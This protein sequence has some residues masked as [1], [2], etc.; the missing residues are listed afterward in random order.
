MTQ[1][2]PNNPGAVNDVDDLT[3]F[4]DEDFGTD[5]VDLFEFT[6]GEEESP[7]TQLKAIILGLDWE[8]TDES[9]QDLADEIEA[10]TQY[11]NEGHSIL[12]TFK[13]FQYQNT[14]PAWDNRGLAP[15]RFLASS[16]TICPR[17]CC[18]L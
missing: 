15:I 7:L 12:G 3:R 18:V 4:L 1:H 14:T 16:Q 9:L 13:V 2:D 17:P 6:G 8:I 5:E 10:V 11:V